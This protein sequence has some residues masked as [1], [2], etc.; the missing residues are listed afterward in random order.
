MGR[1]IPGVLIVIGVV[2]MA[3]SSL[4]GGGVSAIIGLPLFVVGFV[5]LLFPSCRRR[6]SE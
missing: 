5:W 6:R 2:A 1:L 3:V 4:V